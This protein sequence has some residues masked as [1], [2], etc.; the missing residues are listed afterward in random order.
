MRC[1][2]FSKDSTMHILNQI[3]TLDWALVLDNKRADHA[4]FTSVA[5]LL[6]RQGNL[7]ECR[8]EATTMRQVFGNCFGLLR[9]VLKRILLVRSAHTW[10]LAVSTEFW[11]NF[12][13]QIVDFFSVFYICMLGPP[14]HDIEREL[15]VLFSCTHV[16]LLDARPHFLSFLAEPEQLLGYDLTIDLARAGMWTE[17]KNYSSFDRQNMWDLYATAGSSFLLSRKQVRHA[18]GEMD[19]APEFSPSAGTNLCVNCFTVEKP[20]QKCSLCKE[21]SYC[22]RSCQREHWKGTH[23]YTCAGKL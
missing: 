19:D 15:D 11:N 4:V 20:L 13:C 3:S 1:S 7:E 22:G 8:P 9:R 16:S 2:R 12:L 14:P 10:S 21:V 23:R 18:L 17:Q 6:L 5:D